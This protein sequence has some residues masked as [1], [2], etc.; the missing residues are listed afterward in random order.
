MGKY[1]QVENALQDIYGEIAWQPGQSAMDEL[2]SCV[3]SQNTNDTNRD[4]AFDSLKAMYPTWQDVVDA[5][6][7]EVIDTIRSAGLA[8]TKGPRIQ[9]ILRFIKDERGEYNID[10]LKDMPLEDA[11][12]WLTDL[13]GVGPK[14][15]A[16][17]LCFAFNLPAFPVDTHIYRVSK[18]LG[19]YPEKTSIAKAHTIME[20]IV[21]PEKHFAFH[22]YIIRHGTR[23]LQSTKTTLR[24][25]YPDQVLRL[26]QG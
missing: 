17:V 21:P 1:K 9:N 8:N 24:P 23:Y 19:F 18:R 25:M 7:D 26:L 12:T 20:S 3:L 11:R 2:V 13:D 14:T 5:P 10:F 16:I 22:I 4:R 6:T 15:A